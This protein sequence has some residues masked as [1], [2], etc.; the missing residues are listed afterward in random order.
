MHSKTE[1]QLIEQFHLNRLNPSEVKVVHQQ[2]Q[3]KKR[4]AVR[5]KSFSHLFQV[6]KL[7]RR[8]KM[9]M[10]LDHLFENMMGDPIQRDFQN[11]IH[12]LQ[13]LQS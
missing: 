8:K 11:K 9:K 13:K 12:Q 10:K 6:I 7:Y 4:F 3:S 1:W 5:F 2:L